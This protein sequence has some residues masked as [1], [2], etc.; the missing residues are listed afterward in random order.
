MENKFYNTWAIILAAGQGKRMQAV[1]KNKVTYEL[2][3]KPMISYTLS[4]IHSAGVE[5]VLVVVGYEKDSVL[6]LLG[7]QDVSVVQEERLGTGHAVMVAMKDIPMQVE[8]VLVLYGDDSFMYDTEVYKMLLSLHIEK[9]P[10][11]TFLT[12]EVEN[13]TGLGRILRDDNSK[14][15]GIVEEKDATEEQKNINEINPA[16]YVFSVSFLRDYI[17]KLPKSEATGEYYL[18]SLIE[19]AVENNL[20]IETLKRSD[21][22]WQGVNTPEQLQQAESLLAKKV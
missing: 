5:R 16:C 13:P 20:P 15:V 7:K 3:G 14:V 12:L 1:G 21:I 19:M 6:K 2:A 18:T 22:K 17:Q 4:N 10:V 8:Q 11:M 9:K